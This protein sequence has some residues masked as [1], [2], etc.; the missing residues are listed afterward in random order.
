VA[1]AQ[2]ERERDTASTTSKYK[3]EYEVMHD[4]I[5]MMTVKGLGH[6]HSEYTKQAGIAQQ[7]GTH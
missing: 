5:K 7:K 6:K 1:G 4:E 3:V 2:R